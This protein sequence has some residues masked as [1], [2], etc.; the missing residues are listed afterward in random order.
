MSTSRS[1]AA[2]YTYLVLNYVCIFSPHMP[3]KGLYRNY[4]VAVPSLKGPTPPGM[5][6]FSLLFS[7]SLNTDIVL[8]L[9]LSHYYPRKRCRYSVDR[10]L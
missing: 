3:L 4:I 1:Y 7:S 9:F 5:T 2:K 6:L 10:Y 8:F